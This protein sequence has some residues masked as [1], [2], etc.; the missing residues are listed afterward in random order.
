M[1][2]GGGEEEDPQGSGPDGEGTEPVQALVVGPVDVVGDERQGPGRR[3]SLSR[4]NRGTE[5]VGIGVAVE[6]R[7]Q[8]PDQRQAP[9]PIRLVDRAAALG[10]DAP[11]P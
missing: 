7:E 11:Y 10:G 8:A 4:R 9:A 6:L 1:R 2:A 5:R 3:Q